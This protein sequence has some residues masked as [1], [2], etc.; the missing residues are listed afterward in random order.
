MVEKPRKQVSMEFSRRFALESQLITFQGNP[1]NE[2]LV[3]DA[4][5]IR[6]VIRQGPE[7]IPECSTVSAR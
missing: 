2:W 4:T 1:R 6:L 7:A 5:H 3:Y